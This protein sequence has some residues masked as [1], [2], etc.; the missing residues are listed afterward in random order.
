MVKRWH[1]FLKQLVT[2]SKDCHVID[3]LDE[4]VLPV[5]NPILKISDILHQYDMA[6]ILDRINKNGMSFKT[7]IPIEKQKQ[8]K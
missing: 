6:K 8:M 4:F 1:L 7:Q 3:N 2:L 5:E